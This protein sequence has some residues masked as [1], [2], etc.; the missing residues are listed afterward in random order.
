MKTLVSNALNQGDIWVRGEERGPRIRVSGGVW[1]K[2]K[3]RA[4]D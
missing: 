3:V 1:V 2:V 4:R